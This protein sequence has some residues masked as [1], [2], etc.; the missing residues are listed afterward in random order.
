M[1]SFSKNY[2]IVTDN[3]KNSCIL[4]RVRRSSLMIDG[5]PKTICEKENLSDILLQIHV[6]ALENSKTVEGYFTLKR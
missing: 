4:Y 2:S 3:E 5:N 1:S 6:I